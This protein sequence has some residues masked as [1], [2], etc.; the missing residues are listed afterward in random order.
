MRASALGLLAFLTIVCVDASAPPILK[1][2]DGTPSREAIISK[3][4]TDYIFSLTKSGWEAY[5]RRMVSPEGWEIRLFSFDT[6]TVVVTLGPSAAT[7]QR[8]QPL[9]RDDSTPPDMLIVARYYPLGTVGEFTDQLKQHIEAGARQGLGQ[10]YAVSASYSRE[11]LLEMVELT[12][13]RVPD[14]TT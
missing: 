6:G 9:Y 5:A 2:D 10:R 8:I 13:T 11:G 7:G 1:S 12:I 4:E 3:Q 14:S